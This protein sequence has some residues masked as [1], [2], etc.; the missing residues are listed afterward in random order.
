MPQPSSVT[1]ISDETARGGDDLDLA[2]AGVDGVLDQLL[3]DARGPL[4]HLAG[5]DAVDGLGLSWRIGIA[6]PSPQRCDSPTALR[7]DSRMRTAARPA[8]ADAHTNAR[9]IGLYCRPQI[10]T[11]P[12]PLKVSFGR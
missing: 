12:E 5:G 11:M 3:D 9:E 4:D 1:R 8:A 6:G 2:R 7:Q 10:S